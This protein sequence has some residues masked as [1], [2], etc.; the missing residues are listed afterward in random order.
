VTL[1]VLASAVEGWI[2]DGC[3][4]DL[5]DAVEQSFDLMMELCTDWSRA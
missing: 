5:A 2:A 4:G 3:D 1:S